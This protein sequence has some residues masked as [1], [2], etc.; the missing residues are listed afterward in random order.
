MAE[1]RGLKIPFFVLRKEL[2]QGASEGQK[3]GEGEDSPKLSRLELNE[4]QRRMLE[5]LE[6]LC[7]E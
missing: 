5:L 2:V 1:L 4:L 6:D 7:K 3:D